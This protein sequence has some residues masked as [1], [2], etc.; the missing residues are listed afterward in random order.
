MARKV[1]CVKLGREA[2]GLVGAR[3]QGDV[4]G[5]Q[6][7]R[8]GVAAADVTGEGH[9]QPRGLTLE[10]R[11][12]T[13]VADAV[14]VVASSALGACTDDGSFPPAGTQGASST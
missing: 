7:G 1:Q 8:D 11:A 3:G 13:G 12:L 14:I 6:D 9:R 2:E 4:G 5:G 10:P